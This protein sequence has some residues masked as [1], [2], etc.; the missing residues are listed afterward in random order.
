MKRIPLIFGVLLIFASIFAVWASN[1]QIND[2][3]TVTINYAEDSWKVSAYYDR[4]Q[5]IL[6][7]FVPAKDWS[8]ATDPGSD[9]IPFPHKF[10]EVNLTAPNG[11]Y[12][13]F[14]VTLIWNPED[15]DWRYKPPSVFNISVIPPISGITIPELGEEV[16]PGGETVSAIGGVTTQRG[17]YT[18]EIVGMLGPGSPPVWIALRTIEKSTGYPYA[19]MF[20]VGIGTFLCGAVLTSWGLLGAD[21]PTRHKRRRVKTKQFIRK[22][23]IRKGLSA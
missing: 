10:V 15:P 1:K 13:L 17:N 6:F 20:P 21:E 11:E 16:S 3:R 5:T 12:T 7:D 4:N 23:G 22:K 18:G 9:T 8:Q 14:V 19:Y 2:T